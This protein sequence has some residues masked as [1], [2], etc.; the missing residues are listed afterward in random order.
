MRSTCT[1][2]TGSDWL[3]LT[4]LEPLAGIHGHAVRMRARREQRVVVHVDVLDVV[5]EGF[6]LRHLLRRGRGG[7]GAPVDVVPDAGQPPPHQQ[8]LFTLRQLLQLPGQTC[9]EKHVSVCLTAYR[10]VTTPYRP[11][12]KCWML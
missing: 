11:F 12:S 7:R 9:G 10:H 8:A 2:V 1:G 3:T 5:H 6:P 4:W